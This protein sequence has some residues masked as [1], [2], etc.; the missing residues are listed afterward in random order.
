MLH[1]IFTAKNIEKSAN[2]ALFAGV[3]FTLVSF[4]TSSYIFRKTPSLIGVSAIIFTVT[5]T[6]PILLSL[7]NDIALQDKKKS[8][9]AKTKK[10]L[11][12]Y[13]YFFIGSFVI[14][15]LL[16]LVMPSKIMSSDQIYGTAKVIVPQKLGLPSPPVDANQL[17]IGIFR[18]NFSVMIAAFILSIIFGAGSLFLLTLNASIFASALS[19]VLWQTVQNSEYL[20]LYSLISCNMGILFFHMLPEVVGYFLAA[21]AGALLYV[22]ILKE[23][24]FS[25]EFMRTMK[26][27][28]LILLI[29]IGVLLISAIIEVK[30]SRNLISSGLCLK[31]TAHVLIAT[32]LIIIGIIIFEIMRNRHSK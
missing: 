11:D 8:F 14:F 26:K 22:A 24:L 9:A 27:S 23:K 7:F 25:A 2:Y 6:L 20:Y 31:N 3:F 5:M 1:K 10:L 32:F 13:I 18:N 4:I 12:F 28:L 21:I 19:N 30:L 17:I 29:A 15:F 16:S